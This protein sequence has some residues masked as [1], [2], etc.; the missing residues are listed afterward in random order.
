MSNRRLT[1]SNLVK[2]ITAL[3]RD[4]AYGYPSIAKTQIKI[5]RFEGAE[6]PIVIKRWGTKKYPTELKA[7]TTTISSEM[8]WRI[9]SAFQSGVPINFDRI[10]GASYNTRSAFEALLLHTPE[11][12]NC[13]PGRIQTLGSEIK[14][15]AGHKHVLWLPDSPHKLGVMTK[16]E[17]NMVVSEINADS[18]HEGIQISNADPKRSKAKAS[19][20]DRIHAHIQISLYEIGKELGYRTW[21]ASNDQH[22]TYQEKRLIEF[23]E[24]IKDLTRERLFGSYPEAARNGKLID[25]IWFKNGKFMPAVIEVENTTGVLS[26]LL[27]MKKFQD[28]MQNLA[29][30]YWIIVAPDSDRKK[31]FDAIERPEFKSL[32]ARFMPYSAVEELFSLSQRRGLKGVAHNFLENFFENHPAAL[33]NR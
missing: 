29:D 21:I 13:K 7:E 22:I 3:P 20:T 19:S 9:A 17:T 5:V 1:A 18:V 31:V 32:N 14:I 24:V 2:Y 28:S 16:A 8:I 26:G 6:G 12:Y 27:R 11:F 33:I 30:V 23:D 25:A 4:V 10:L 15:K